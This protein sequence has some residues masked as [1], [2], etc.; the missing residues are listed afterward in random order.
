M[1]RIIIISNR[2]PITIQQKAEGWSFVP[3]AGGLATGL[4]S[5]GDSMERIWVG[6]PGEEIV[7][8]LAQVA[9]Q[10]DL[11]KDGLVPVFLSKKEIELYYEGF[12][13]KTIWPHFH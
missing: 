13:N 1:S 5:L 11:W 2:L 10:E 6:W 7:S 8:P 9:V 3:S 4:M 12:S